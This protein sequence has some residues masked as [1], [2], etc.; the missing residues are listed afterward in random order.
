VDTKA[1]GTWRTGKAATIVARWLSWFEYEM[2]PTVSCVDAW[3][4]DGDG[5][6]RGGGNL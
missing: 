2:S 4:P 3:S 1:T 5:I 6:L